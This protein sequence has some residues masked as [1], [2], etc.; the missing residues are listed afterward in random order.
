MREVGNGPARNLAQPRA[1]RPLHLRT[2]RRFRLPSVLRPVLRNF[3]QLL[4]LPISVALLPWPFGFRW[5]RLLTR[6]PQ[7]YRR[8]QTGCIPQAIA[9]GVADADGRAFA[10]QQRLLRLVDHADLYL[11][12]TRSDRWMRRYLHV[13]GQWPATPFLAIG[14]HWG[15]GM[16]ALRHAGAHGAN[17]RTLSI[18]FDHSS[19]VGEPFMYRYALRRNAEVARAARA[20]VVMRG[21]GVRNLLRALQRGQNVLALVDVPGADER[22]GARVSLLGH[23][24]LMPL[25]VLQLAQRAG[26]PVVPF[27]CG[28]D[29]V[30]GRRFLHIGAP[31]DSGDAVALAQSLAADL[32]RLLREAPWAW[33]L[34]A[35]WPGFLAPP[36]AG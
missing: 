33:H 24:V 27:W 30:D 13:D 28:F 15:T 7:I 32:D 31:R 21:A 5:A 8:E 1:A 19:F 26:V 2:F 11:S 23:E 12:R 35:Q 10:R 34:W 20:E 4:L 16:W 17:P 36:R 29:L 6:F 3:V 14:F 22:N 25:G 18:E 9:V